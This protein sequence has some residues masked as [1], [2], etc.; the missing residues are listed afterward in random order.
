GARRAVPLR[1][2]QVME[3]V[4][5]AIKENDR[6]FAEIN[7]KLDRRGGPTCPPDR[8]VGAGF[9]PAPTNTYRIHKPHWVENTLHEPINRIYRQLDQLRATTDT[10]EEELEL[11]SWMKKIAALQSELDVFFEQSLEDYVYWVELG[12]GGFETRPYNNS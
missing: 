10:H 5:E 8:N 11:N 9:K 7:D 1:N 12:R 3:W 4:T 6:M 2:D